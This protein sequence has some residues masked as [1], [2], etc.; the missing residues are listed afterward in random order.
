MS[1]V[2]SARR[3]FLAA[4]NLA[5]DR[6]DEARPAGPWRS[7]E[8]EHRLRRVEISLDEAPHTARDLRIGAVAQHVVRHLLDGRVLQLAARGHEVPVDRERR[9]GNARGAG[10]G[11][12]ALLRFFRAR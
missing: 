7:L 5:E 1:P 10:L 11:E 9:L 3:L 12:D 6:A 8:D 2:Y 4:G